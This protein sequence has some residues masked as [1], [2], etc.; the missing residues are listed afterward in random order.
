MHARF[1]APGVTAPGDVVALPDDEAQHLTRVL[2]LGVGST[3]RIF[4]GR[5]GEFDAV[6]EEAARREVRVRA[7]ERRNAAP[8]PRIAITLAQAVLK[9]DRMDGVVRDAAMIGAAA[10]QPMVT[11][12]TEVTL[13]ALDRGHRRERWERIAVASVKQCRRAVVPS[14]LQPVTFT[15]ILEG[16]AVRALPLPALLFAEPGAAADVIASGELE[17]AA[18]G[19]ATV[20]IGPE[21]GWAPEEIDAASRG[22]R[23]VT[24]GGRTLRADAMALAAMAA[25]FTRWGEF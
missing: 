13:A 9:S 7:G 15:A 11:A 20:L 18:P 10:I 22:C 24:L 8:E 21:G 25:L 19:E 4:N 14:I 6:V 23:L 2:R 16:L 1:Y 17:M 5:G 12:H 3:V